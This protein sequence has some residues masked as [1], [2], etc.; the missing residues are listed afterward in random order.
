[1]LMMQAGPG[2]P[3]R[4]AGLFTDP[5]HARP[6]S[7]LRSLPSIYLTPE[8]VGTAVAQNSNTV[9]NVRPALTMTPRQVS[10]G[11]AAL[12]SGRP[13]TSLAPFEDGPMTTRMAAAMRSDAAR[14]LASGWR[15]Q[16][17]Y[18]AS[19]QPVYALRTDDGCTLTIFSVAGTVIQRSLRT[20]IASAR[21]YLLEELAIQPLHGETDESGVQ[22][23]PV[24]AGGQL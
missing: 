8:G 1:M 12:I 11:Y 16:Y 18:H 21:H 15:V 23:L 13:D 6:G 20:G 9:F 22:V 17:A 7:L 10:I 2:A 3:W 14:A 4:E 19:G 24:T 5:A